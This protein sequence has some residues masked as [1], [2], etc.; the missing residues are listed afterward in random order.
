MDSI[1][2]LD[3]KGHI[4]NAIIDVFEAMLSMD[5]EFPDTSPNFPMDGPQIVGSVSFAGKAMG[6]INL[7]LGEDFARLITA[8]MLDMDED[9]IEGDEEIHDVVGE[10]SNMIGGDLKSRLCDAGLTCKLSIPTI[11]SGREFRVEPKGWARHE[12][13]VFNYKTQT[14]LVDVYLKSVN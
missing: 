6:S 5:V 13:F 7:R 10:L 1:N 9:E 8:A 3:L 12:S 11:T 4:S 14:G 2:S